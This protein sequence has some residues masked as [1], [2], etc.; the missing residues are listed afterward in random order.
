[1]SEPEVCGLSKYWFFKGRF[2]ECCIEHDKG[3]DTF[4]ALL[5]DL[6]KEFLLC[7]IDKST[8]LAWIACAIS[9]FLIAHIYGRFRYRQKK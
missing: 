9:L 1:M 4:E 8:S 2:L 5:F 3:Y 6:D 7:T